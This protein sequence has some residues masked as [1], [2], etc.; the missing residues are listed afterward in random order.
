MSRHGRH[1]GGRAAAGR[2]R[3]ALRARLLRALRSIGL[4]LGSA[5]LLALA[6]RLATAPVLVRGLAPGRSARRLVL[7]P[8]VGGTEDVVA[9]LEGRGELDLEL[10]RLPRSEVKAVWRAV[11]GPAATGLGDTHYLTQDPMV[12]AAK[13][14]YRSLLRRILTRYAASM[15][16]TGLIG[17]N[18]AYYAERELAAAAEEIGIPFL[19]LH[20]ES[21]R[22]PAQRPWF[23]R[24]YRERIGPFTGRSMA[25]YNAGERDSLI[26]AGVAPAAS[27][28]VTGSPRVD[29]LHRLRERSRTGDVPPSPRTVLFAIDPAA[30]AWTPYDRQER[31]GAPRWF[32]LARLTE[33]GLIEAALADPAHRFAIK[34]KLGREDVTLARLPAR[35]PPNLEV[36][37]GGTATRLLESAD[38]AIAFN[39]TVI[40]EAI[41]AG[42]PVL[43]PCFGEAQDAPD[44]VLPVDGAVRVLSDA[45]ELPAAIHAARRAGRRVELSEA[46]RRT[47]R[48]LVGDDAGRA[49]DRVWAWLRSELALVSRPS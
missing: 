24:A 17:A 45:D 30:G 47:L 5:T 3:V 46:D 41:A 33:E 28:H 37:T 36:V 13:Q 20:K 21:I 18:F 12:E 48:D 23:T 35:R 27:I 49:G 22:A 25:V 43:I 31:V 32:E 42:V 44:W 2:A 1:P 11:M 8:K 38:V 16:V 40:A 39:T 34:V 15:R 10:V 7:L 6:W 19:V 14:R 29:A 4:R 26:A 9:A